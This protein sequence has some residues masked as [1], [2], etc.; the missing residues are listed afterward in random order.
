MM[1]GWSLIGRRRRRSAGFRRVLA[2]LAVTLPSDA[3]VATFSLDHAD[4]TTGLDKVME[5]LGAALA[6]DAVEQI[7]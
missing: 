5:A 3:N 1:F 2:E 6:R 7:A 4:V